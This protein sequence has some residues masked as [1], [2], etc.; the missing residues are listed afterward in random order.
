V[1][2][3]PEDVVGVAA[4]SPGHHHLDRAIG[5]RALSAERNRRQ[6]KT[7]NEFLH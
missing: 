2:E 7:C 5:I 3:W 6:R 4:G 1:R